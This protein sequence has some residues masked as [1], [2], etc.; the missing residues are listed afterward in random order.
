MIIGVFG[1]FKDVQAPFIYIAEKLRQFRLMD[2][3][4]TV[5]GQFGEAI[6]MGQGAFTDSRYLRHDKAWFHFLAA[7]RST[8]F[9][10]SSQG[11]GLLMA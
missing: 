5:L 1:N 4:D 6:G 9:V 2:C 7:N 8:T 11:H 3:F 10:G